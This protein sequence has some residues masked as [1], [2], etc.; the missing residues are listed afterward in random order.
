LIFS[1]NINQGDG[2]MAC[3]KDQIASLSDHA[4]NSG[5]IRHIPRE[6]V[7]MTTLDQVLISS[8]V[9]RIDVMKMDVERYECVVLTGG[10]QLVSRFHPKQLMIEARSSGGNASDALHNTLGCVVDHVMAGGS[11]QLHD[12]NFAGAVISTPTQQGVFNLFFNSA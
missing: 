4:H 8:A 3:G 11:Y 1:A 10:S 9:P 12:K 6:T 7:P 2:M 5:G